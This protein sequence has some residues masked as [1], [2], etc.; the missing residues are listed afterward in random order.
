MCFYRMA[1]TSITTLVKDGWCWWYRKYAPGDTVLEGL[2]KEA[3]EAKKGLWADPQPVPPWEWRKRGQNNSRRAGG[4]HRAATGIAP[5]LRLPSLPSYN[6]PPCEASMPF[7]I[8]PYRRF[9]VQCSVTYNTGS[10]QGQGIIWNLSCTGWRL[11]GDLPMRTGETLSL[12]VTLPNEQRIEIQKRGDSG[13][14]GSNGCQLPA[15]LNVRITESSIH[16]LLHRAAHTPAVEGVVRLRVGEHEAIGEVHVPRA[17][18]LP[19]SVDAD[20]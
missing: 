14:G 13:A 3:R 15:P 7:S 1:P 16:R 11:S 17:G 12:T 2:E 20:Q 4:G 5:T 9:P 6:T 19:A 10:F 18:R 8:R